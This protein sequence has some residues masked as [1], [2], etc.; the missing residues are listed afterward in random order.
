MAD[1]LARRA[2]YRDR[3]RDRHCPSLEL[4]RAV[5]GQMFSA[6]KPADQT[7]SRRPKWGLSSR[8]RDVL[9]TSQMSFT[10][11]TSPG[12]Y[13]VAFLSFDLGAIDPVD[14]LDGKDRYALL[15]WPVTAVPEITVLR[16]W[17]AS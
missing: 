4:R 7:S 1:D 9:T 11:S 17:K 12:P 5:I 16:R 6:S 14:G 15:L 13:G 3:R 8:W 2:A 10:L